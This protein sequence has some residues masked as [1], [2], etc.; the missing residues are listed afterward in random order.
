LRYLKFVKTSLHGQFWQ[1]KH[2]ARVGYSIDA[3]QKNL[4][5][6]NYINRE[7]ATATF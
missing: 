4:S 2:R 7:K 3:S 5:N 6:C 1:I